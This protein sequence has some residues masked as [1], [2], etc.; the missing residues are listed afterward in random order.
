MKRVS[1]SISTADRIT[2]NTAASDKPENQVSSRKVTMKKSSSAAL[3]SGQ[4]SVK[5]STKLKFIRP[6]AETEIK[7][8]D[9]HVSA[10]LFSLN[11]SATQKLLLK[12]S[13]NT[14]RLTAFKIG[15][16]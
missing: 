9:G 10:Q 3:L 4:H 1:V 15:Q 11:A 5:P 7:D 12:P 16:D 6:K 14:F 13:P 8:G 2:V